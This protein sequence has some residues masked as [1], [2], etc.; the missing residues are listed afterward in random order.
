MI[1]N[2]GS[3]FFTNLFKALLQKYDMKHK[4]ETPYHT[5]I[6]GQV[7][8]SN[9]ET[10]RIFA[11]TENANRTIWL[12]LDVHFRSTKDLTRLNTPN[13]WSL[14]NFLTCVPTS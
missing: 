3:H 5:Q 6:S 13:F 10:K 11:R 4:F 12:I 9:W 8:V 1:N 7:M 2:G 14:K